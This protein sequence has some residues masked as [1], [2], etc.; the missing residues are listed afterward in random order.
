MNE[1][2]LSR[3]IIGDAMKV[4]TALEDVWEVSKVSLIPPAPFSLTRRRARE[5][6]G[7]LSLSP[8]F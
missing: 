7:E 6:G 1:N 4:H 2:E 5:K 8:P 3:V